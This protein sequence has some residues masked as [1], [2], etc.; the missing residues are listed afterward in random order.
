ML[1]LILNTFAVK[2]ILAGIRLVMNIVLARLLGPELRGL[3]YVIQNIVGFTAS[4]STLSIGEA[5]I[6]F[7]GKS[8]LGVSSMR[9]FSFVA[10]ALGGFVA[11]A[12]WRQSSAPYADKDQ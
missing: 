9:L 5:Y 3:Y 11:I 2:L 7:H 10:T 8:R 1:K 6:Y 4:F 12:M